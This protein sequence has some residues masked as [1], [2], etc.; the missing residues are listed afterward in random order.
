MVNG[1]VLFFS[2]QVLLVESPVPGWK[3]QLVGTWQIFQSAQVLYRLWG[4][5]FCQFH[6]IIASLANFSLLFFWRE[7]EE[8]VWVGRKVVT[9]V[10]QLP[11]RSYQRCDMQTR[12]KGQFCFVLTLLPRLYAFLNKGIFDSR[13]TPITAIVL[14]AHLADIE[15]VAEVMDSNLV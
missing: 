8:G 14:I 7:R 4:E 2:C 11:V 5:F 15:A 9:Y 13:L 1:V 10:I 3:S 12:Q 6:H